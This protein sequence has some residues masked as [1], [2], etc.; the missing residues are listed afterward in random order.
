MKNKGIINGALSV[1]LILAVAG[2][3]GLLGY[4]VANPG[5]EKFTEVYLL[6]LN[7][8]ATDYPEKLK[9]GEEGKVI[10]GIVNQEY[11]P[12]TYRVEILIDTVKNSEIG[13]V[14]LEHRGKWEEIVS[15][16]P[17]RVG[18][19]QKVEFWLYRQDQNEVYQKLHLWVD[20]IEAEEFKP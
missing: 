10:L 11:E 3:L 13:P 18:D 19:N 17:N 8:K 4:I 15:F 20:V 16:T 12:L 6:G 1:I 14:T 5:G 2:A 9:V 7:G